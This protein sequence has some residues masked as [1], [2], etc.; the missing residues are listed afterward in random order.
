MLPP[1]SL[2]LRKVHGQ[3][4]LV[5]V[6]IGLVVDN[7]VGHDKQQEHQHLDELL[8]KVANISIWMNSTFWSLCLRKVHGD[9]DVVGRV[10]HDKRTT[11]AQEIIQRSG[12]FRHEV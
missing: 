1:S 12:A 3:V 7:L 6:H 2:R 5:Q 11:D 10:G 8:H 4:C 9:V